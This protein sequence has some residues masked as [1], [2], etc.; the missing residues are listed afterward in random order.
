MVD[1]LK[2]LHK[3]NTDRHLILLI[4]MDAFN[5]LPQWHDYLSLFDYANILVVNRTGTARQ[6]NEKLQALIRERLVPYQQLYQHKQ[7]KITF[8]ELD[9]IP[10]SSTEIRNRLKNSQPINELVPDKVATYITKHD[11]Y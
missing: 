3:E 2:S 10:V 1:T 7:G 9:E 8:L 4:G 11:L 5:S 6:F